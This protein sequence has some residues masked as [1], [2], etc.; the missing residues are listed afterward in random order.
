MHF[1]ARTQYLLTLACL[2]VGSIGHRPWSSTFVCLFSL[3]FP[4]YPIF[5]LSFS[6]SLCQVFLGLPLFLF[7]CGFHVRACRVTFVAGFLSV[8]PQC[9]SSVCVLSVFPQCVSSVCVLSVCPQCVSSVCVL[10]VC[11][12][13]VSSVCV[14]SVCPIH[15]HFLFFISFSTN[16]CLVLSHSVVLY[17]FSDH[18]RSKI[19]RRHLLMK[20]CI[21]FSVFCIIRHVSEP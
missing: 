21:L 13:C 16:S 14:L 12:Q 10:S 7:P 19:L 4:V 5:F 20:I 3:S 1:R 15:L 2:L 9:V 6:V 17:I 8:C 11:P 18:F